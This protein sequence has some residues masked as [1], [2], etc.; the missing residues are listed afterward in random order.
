MMAK[1]SVFSILLFF[2]FF[3]ISKAQ[4]TVHKMV[5]VGY[6]YQNQSFAELGGRLLFLKNDD[7]IYRLGVA[8]MIGSVNGQFAVVPK[9]QGD[10]LLNFERNVDLY[11]SIYFLAGAEATTKY[12]APKAGVTLF[13]LID[14]TGGYAFPIDRA[15]INGKELKGLNFNF[16]INLPLVMLHDLLK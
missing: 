5:H 11:H 15:G 2:M 12:V 6:V 1:R 4:F 7:M 13:G 10:I 14:F 9:I 8:G 3:G 16:T